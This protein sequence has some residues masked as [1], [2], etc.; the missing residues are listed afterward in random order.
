MIFL[1]GF[2]TPNLEEVPEILYIGNDGDE[3]NRLA[4]GSRLPRLAKMVNPQLYPIRHWSEEASAAFTESAELE[5]QAAEQAAKAAAEKAEFEKQLA[6]LP[7]AAAVATS[8][9]DPVT[10]PAAA[11]AVHETPAPAP[12][13]TGAESGAESAQAGPSLAAP[14]AE[15]PRPRRR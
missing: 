13:G 1:L 2:R 7:S 5:K 6:G 15:G 11:P 4:E 12:V 14:T 10:Q 8:P 3:V 9:S